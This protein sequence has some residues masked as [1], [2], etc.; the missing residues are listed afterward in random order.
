MESRTHKLVDEYEEY[1][2]TQQEMNEPILRS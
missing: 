1:K 2:N